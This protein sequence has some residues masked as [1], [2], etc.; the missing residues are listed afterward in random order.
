MR[1]WR[2]PAIFVLAG[3]QHSWVQDPNS[4]FSVSSVFK[5]FC[6]A[7]QFCT[8]FCAALSEAPR[9]LYSNCNVQKDRCG[10]LAK[11]QALIQKTKNG[12]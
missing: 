4:G 5:D 7:R 8:T 12:T 3:N 11:V 2:N 9:Q 1:L 10:D 6:S